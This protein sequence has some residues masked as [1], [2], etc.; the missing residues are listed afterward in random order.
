MSLRD[1][2]LDALRAIVGDEFVRAEAGELLAYECDGFPIAKGLPWAVVLPGSADEAA[3]CMAALHAHGVV[4]VPRGSG[5]GLAGGCVGFG[6]AVIVCTSRMRRILEIDIPGRS[7]CVEAGVLNTELTRAVQRT[8]G[9]AGLHFAPD[10]SSQTASTV[11]GNVASNAGGLHTLKHGVTG[12]HLL[13]VDLI[14]SDGSVVTARGK[15]ADGL[16]PNLPGLVCGSEGTLGLVTKAWVK[17]TP[18]PRAFR[19]VVAIFD[20][21]FNASAAVAGIIESGIVPAA[22]EMMDGKMVEVVEDAFAFGFPRD[23][24]ALLLIEVDGVEAVLDAEMQQVAEICHAHHAER[25]DQSGD[26]KRRAEL[27]SARKRAFGAI[28]RISPSYCTQDACV[29]RSKLPEVLTRCGEIGRKYGMTITNVFHAGDGNVHP[30]LLFD[31]D[32]PEQ[33]RATMQASHEILEY[34]IAIGG[35]LT[36]EHGVGV[37]KLPLMRIMFDP[38]TLDAFAAIKRAFDPDELSN[39]GKLLPSEK[40]RVDLLAP[41]G[42]KSP[43]GALA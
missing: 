3:G 9:G 35:S 23:A 39:P 7:A 13:G 43:G 19:T 20:D 24:Q 34:C 8:P 29:P 1:A 21:S 38:P 41:S 32:D 31:E 16:G 18:A 42:G 22:M 28:G 40:L 4:G 12:E 36:G 15:L 2:T 26:P 25:V 17:L 33:V 5:T 10:P 30:I 11:A 6:E 27:W 37:E 14:L